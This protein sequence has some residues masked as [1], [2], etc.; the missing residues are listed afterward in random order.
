MPDSSTPA[1]LLASLKANTAFTPQGETVGNLTLGRGRL[2]GVEVFVAI[3]EN[4][5]ASG[6]LGVRE[7]DQLASLFRIVAAQ[8]APLL[9]YLD[10]AGA[11]V[12]EGLPALG[13]F[14]H[15]YRAALAMALS[16]T[17]F[18]VLLGTHCYGGASML[19]AL[20]STRVFSANTQLAMSGPSILAQ[21]AGATADDAMFRAIAQAAIGAEGRAKLGQGNSLHWDATARHAPPAWHEHHRQ[22]G[23]RL[24]A[25]TTSAMRTEAVQREDFTARYPRGHLLQEQ[26][27]IL[28]GGA[29]DAAGAITLLGVADKKPLGAARAWAL[30]DQIWKLGIEKPARLHLLVDCEAHAAALDD[31]R[32]MLSSYLADAALAL[33]TLSKG[34][35]AIETTVLGQLGGGVYV[36]LAAASAQVNL[37][38]G[39]VIHLLPSRAIAS[40][41]GDA[42]TAPHEIDEYMQARVAERELK[43]GFLRA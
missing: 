11:R 39:A 40:I 6:S 38:H 16:G 3:V 26:T 1:V 9:L 4:R 17:Q 34:G 42:Q 18:T 36:L 23:E 35:T 2:N 12:S 37:L 25:V 43:V 10:S 31:E 5:I 27:G 19:A 24:A 33:A 7:C 21:N 22:L 30:A 20:A 28:S 32:I 13:A 29:N 41:L 14:R 8:K 15:M